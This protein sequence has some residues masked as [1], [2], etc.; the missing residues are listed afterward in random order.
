M[1][2]ICEACGVP[3]PADWTAGDRCTSCGDAVRRE[4]R[5]WWCVEWAPAGAFCRGCGADLVADELFPAARMLKDAGADRFRVPALLTELGQD[6]VD[7]FT[8]IFQRH[9]AVLAAHVDELADVADVLQGEGRGRRLGLVDQLE[10]EQLPR[11]PWPTEELERNEAALTRDGGA[12]GSLDRLRRIR[13]RT[14]FELTRSAAGAALLAAGE[15]S[16]ASV[17]ID[18]MHASVVPELRLA[19]ALTLTG[20]RARTM[21]DRSDLAW[22][23]ADLADVLGAAALDGDVR[24]SVR[25]AALARTPDPDALADLGRR[26]DLDA[27][28]AFDLAL[29]TGDVDVLRT[30]LAAT[31]IDPVARIA[32]TRALVRHGHTDGLGRVL[33]DG[34]E[35]V[36]DEVL[37]ELAR[38][39]VAVADAERELVEIAV[40]SADPSVAR[41]AAQVAARHLGRGNALRV[42]DARIG[43]PS[44]VQ[45]LLQGAGVDADTVRDLADLLLERGRFSTAQFG[46]STVAEDGRLGDDWVPSRFADASPAA[47][48]EL[49]EVAELQLGARASDALHRFVLSVLFGAVASEVRVAAL[50]ALRRWYR[51]QGD[52]RGEGPLAL[53]ATGL[54]AVGWAVDDAIGGLARLLRDDAA[55]ADVGLFEWTANLARSAGDEVVAA[56][57]PLD[58][59]HPELAAAIDDAIAQDHWGPLTQELQRLRDRLGVAAG[60]ASRTDRWN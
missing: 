42:A 36:I 38:V 48:V 57:A 35:L 9:A 13:E 1:R 58:A 40:S 39:K 50:W 6:R 22:P 29:I 47:Q 46:V 21:V 37:R 52:M 54:A 2:A 16:A 15:W 41:R 32:A 34:P 59:N 5:C 28:A 44:V 53:T 55:L 3:Q 45:S 24:A 14:P 30:A 49:I 27:D 8:R 18:V 25:L 7:N 60:T 43:D 56:L 20:W 26:I 51:A 19:A 23:S 11:L 17:V 33:R 10:S 12:A 4:V 31:P